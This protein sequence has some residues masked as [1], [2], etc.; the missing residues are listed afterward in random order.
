MDLIIWAGKVS[1]SWLFFYG[2]YRLFFCNL[3]HLEWNRFYLIGT[4]VVSLLLPLIELPS[5]VTDPLVVYAV[6]LDGYLITPYESS[7][8]SFDWLMILGVVYLAGALLM[9]ARFAANLWKL[10]QVWQKATRIELGEENA[11]LYLFADDSVKSF[12]FIGRIGINHTDYHHHF[13]LIFRHEL[14]H[15][16]QLHSMDILLVEVLKI[17]FWFHPVLLYYKESLRELHEYLADR[18]VENRDTYAEFL[19]AYTLSS[20]DPVL[21]TN[22]YKSS[23]LKQR[24][25]MM[26]KDQSPKWKRSLYVMTALLGVGIMAVVAAC[27]EQDRNGKDLGIAPTEVYTAVEEVPEFPGGAKAMYQYLASQIRFPKEAI[28]N[29]VSGRVFLQFVV[30]KDGSIGDVEIIKGIGYGCDAEAVRVVKSMP[31]WK[32]GREKG[33]PVNVKYTLPVAF[34]QEDV[35]LEKQKEP[36][37]VKIFSLPGNEGEKPLFIVDGKELTIDTQVD[38]DAIEK[39]D[40]LKGKAAI[41]KYGAKGNSG[42]VEITLKKQ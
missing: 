19:V 29:N 4:L 12:S 32:P 25:H 31:N 33:V 38:Q 42:V 5:L 22:F 24:I 26:Y 18:E 36:A 14:V 23:L 8:G 37:G 9:A 6:P 17:F 7:S 21:V 2:C 13:D 1:I 15:V 27:S 11:A 40:V 39:V 30:R 10:N 16:K 35:S 28:E 41:Q 34:L 3:T 20:T